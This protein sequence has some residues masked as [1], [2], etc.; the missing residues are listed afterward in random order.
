MAMNRT[1]TTP[2][3]FVQTLCFLLGIL[4]NHTVIAQGQK[5]VKHLSGTI[6]VGESKTIHINFDASAKV[7]YKDIGSKLV[8]LDEQPA[9]FRMGAQSSFE[10][11]NLT[12]KLQKGHTIYYYS[13]ILKYNANPAVLN[14]FVEDSDAI[15]VLK[16]PTMTEEPI[17]KSA[18]SGE[19]SFA[20]HP[21]GEMDTTS[22][23]YSTC[24]QLLQKKTKVLAGLIHAKLTL[25]LQGL[26]IDQ[27]RL[28]F[29]IQ[30]TNASNI[31]YDVDYF[32]FTIR[33]RSN[34][35]KS[36]SQE[37]ELRPLYVYGDDIGRIP[38]KGGTVTKIFVFNKFTLT[39]DK[40]LL[41]DLGERGG[42]RNLLLTLGGEVILGAQAIN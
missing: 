42:D 10:E 12:F 26:Y 19:T 9:L 28:Y 22:E 33:I 6:E 15:R 21:Q 32:K 30:T 11:T 24:R 31:P 20:P 18:L 38:P 14:Y 2:I 39:T 34:F 37:S 13:Y 4:L 29:V 27:D 7:I 5:P 25:Q 41:V 8:L 36:A 16:A 35:R 1:H 17:K 23:Y 3:A 40:K